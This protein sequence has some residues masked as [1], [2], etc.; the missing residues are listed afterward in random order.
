MLSIPVVIASILMVGVLSNPQVTTKPIT[1][2]YGY[3]VMLVVDVSGSMGVGYSTQTPFG[4]SY[5]IFTSLTSKRG[6]L[7]FG[8]LL[9]SSDI[10]I[11]RYFIN[12]DEL[13][14]DTLDNRRE[15]AYLSVGTRVSAALATAHQ[16]LTDKIDGQDKAVICITDL[17]VSYQESLKIVSEMNRMSMI[18]IKTYII[19]PE[20]SIRIAETRGN[21]V[22]DFKVVSMDDEEGIEQICQEIS[23][24]KMS[25][26]REDEGLLKKSLIPFLILPALGVIV[27]CL[28]LGETRFLKIP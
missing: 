7:N 5:K 8:L 28:I 4:R 22:M 17:D 18:G 1:Y 3:P 20:E 19:A 21:G 6:D 16:F 2:V 14:Q 26:I 10:Y 23:E 15:V 12:K 9:F 13:F 24:M 11:A 27:L 25:L